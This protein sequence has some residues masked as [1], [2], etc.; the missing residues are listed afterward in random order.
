MPAVVELLNGKALACDY[1][2]VRIKFEAGKVVC[3]QE[4]KSYQSAEQ[5]KR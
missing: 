5:M 3:V 2:E 4:E 1:G